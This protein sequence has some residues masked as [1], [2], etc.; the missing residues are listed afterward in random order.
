[1]I[2][3]ENPP[4]SDIKSHS[5]RP[6]TPGQQHRMKLER[7]GVRERLLR[8]LASGELTST[9]L[10]H[11]FHVTTGA[12]SDFKRRHAP[13]IEQ[14]RVHLADHFYGLWAADKYD[15]VATL[16]SHV[17]VLDARLHE[18]AAGEQRDLVDPLTGDTVTVNVRDPKAL[19]RLATTVVG[20]LRLISE[21]L[22]QLPTRIQTE[23]VG[24]PMRVVLEIEGFSG[25][26][27]R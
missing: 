15:R 2:V 10:A 6:V 1:M 21:E 3:T 25:D 19:A 9:T 12:I 13:E 4:K 8:N 11:R 26:E 17:E 5:E 14:I 22:G 7:S 24:E 18:L 27:L 23:Q 20:G 16:Q